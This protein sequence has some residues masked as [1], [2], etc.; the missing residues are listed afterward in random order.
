MKRQ[1]KWHVAATIFVLILSTGACTP[2]GRK[3]TAVIPP[4]E[5]SLPPDTP[6][7]AAPTA[8]ATRVV[9]DPTATFTPIPVTQGE[10]TPTFT[11]T[12]Q[13]A[14]VGGGQP[15]EAPISYVITRV[16]QVRDLV[17]NGSFE[18]GFGEDGVAVGWA[19]FDNKDA[20]YAWVDDL[21]PMHV[22]HG[23]HAQL[24][25]TMGP[26]QPDRYVG[27]YQ[28]VDV[29]PGEVYT[30]TMHGLIRSST[31][32]D[33][34]TPY[35]HRMQYAIDDQGGTNWH[36]MFQDWDNWIDPG[37]NDV[38]L[39]DKEV[40]M[41]AYVIQITPPNDKLT[42]FIRGWTKW[43]I[44]TSEAKFYIDGVFLEG[45]VPGE[46][47]VVTV[48]APAPNTGG[49]N[50]PTTGATAAWIPITGIVFVLGFALWEIRKVWSR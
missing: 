23:S 15:A 43:P 9:Q 8:T 27:I 10:A 4:T 20:V 12:S 3:A 18:D 42:L 41:N 35:G 22:S 37:W 17:K 19:A 6:L 16:P 50:M 45:P 2:F 46:Q 31:A 21:Q 13:P 28:T 39:D 47:E 11:P 5:T 7:P 38:L 29:V 40:T 33:S 49:E 30:L 26:G 24:M 25:R 44:I 14:Q 1:L 32:G 48:V 34:K 36:Q